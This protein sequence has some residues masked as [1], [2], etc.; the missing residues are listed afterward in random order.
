[1]GDPGPQPISRRPHS[2]AA[3]PFSCVLLPS[4]PPPPEV[5]KGTASVGSGE[6]SEERAF[7]PPP[8]RPFPCGHATTP[9]RA[10]GGA[11][12][13]PS[14]GC[15]G[16]TLLAASEPP[17]PPPPDL[18]LPA[19]AADGA[20][21]SAADGRSGGGGGG[22]GGR[23][24]G[25]AVVS[26]ADRSRLR[27]PPAGAR[28]ARELRFHTQHVIP[29]WRS[30][31]T[32]QP[33]AKPSAL[34]LGKRTKEGHGSRLGPVGERRCRAQKEE[35]IGDATVLVLVCLRSGLPAFDGDIEQRPNPPPRDWQPTRKYQACEGLAR[36]RSWRWRPMRDERCQILA[37]LSKNVGGGRAR[38]SSPGR[39]MSKHVPRARARRAAAVVTTGRACLLASAGVARAASWLVRATGHGEWK[40]WRRWWPRGTGEEE[41]GGGH[42]RFVSFSFFIGNS[43]ICSAHDSPLQGDPG[44]SRQHSKDPS[45]VRGWFEAPTWQ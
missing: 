22:G 28:G 14:A 2:V 5:F 38:C 25:A 44:R 15:P 10:G 36:G 24:P 18:Q 16:P 1:M 6:R 3:P 34:T 33:R 32:E 40:K 41:L 35:P 7:P 23:G 12:G 45:S 29:R 17:P 43:T 21:R 9:H 26:A 11:P 31:R 39:G 30:G 20:R 4:P 8:A 19:R 37:V 27:T 13:R 42:P